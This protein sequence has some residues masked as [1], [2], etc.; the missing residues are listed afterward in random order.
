MPAPNPRS[1][2]LLNVFI[3]VVVVAIAGYLTFSHFRTS[4][5]VST[6]KR[7]SAVDTVTGSVTVHAEKDLQEIKSDLPGRVVWIDPRQLGEPIKAGDRLVELDSTDLKLEMKQAEEAYAAFVKRTE[8]QIQADPTIAVAEQNLEI[9]KRRREHQEISDIDLATV[10]NAL[11]KAKTDRLLAD[12]DAQQG[13]LKFENDQGAR[14]RLL[15]K[16][17]IRAPMDCILQAVMVA[18]GALISAGTPVAAYFSNERSVIAKV[19]EEDIGKVKIGQKARV[20][21][22]RIP[23]QSFEAEVTTILPFAEADTQ[24]YSVYLKVNAP[25]SVL[26]PFATG[27]AVIEVG[28]HENQ[29]IVERTALVNDDVVMVVK[30]GVVE[31]RQVKVGFKALNSVEIT[32]N[33]QPGETVIVDDADQFRDGQHVRV[34]E[35]K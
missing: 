29:P 34:I 14:K 19:A 18:P 31:K 10:E 7:D 26:E 11:K 20:R 28:R 8:I 2:I 15:E 27:E 9:A 13:K 12:H 6:V 1:Q 4:A 24:R 17:T 25:L 22:L 23:G 21:L 33:L 16:M 30:G 3:V 35:K 5:V 32:E